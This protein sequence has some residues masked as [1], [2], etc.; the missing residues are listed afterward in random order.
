MRQLI[1]RKGL[2]DR[3]QILSPVAREKLPS[4]LACMD[5]L[6]L[7]SR[8]TD[9]WME[10]LGRVMVEA[11]AVGVPV[12]GSESGAIPEVLDDAG[13]LYAEDEPGALGR[14]LEKIMLDENLRREMIRRGKARVKERY[15][16]QRF[17]D[18]TFELYQRVLSQ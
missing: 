11:M 1:A 18:E 5:V 16:W 3:T 7:P 15:N 6:V 10:Q 8:T 12:I 14:C 9:G 17:A 2:Q 4:Y 13:M